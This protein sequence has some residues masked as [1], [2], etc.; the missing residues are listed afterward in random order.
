MLAAMIKHC[1]ICGKYIEWDFHGLCHMCRVAAEQKEE[2]EQDRRA[3]VAVARA[4]QLE[5]AAEAAWVTHITDDPC[6]GGACEMLPGGQ[7]LYCEHGRTLHMAYLD[8]VDATA[9]NYDALPAP[10][11]AEIESRE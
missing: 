7:W 6:V 10:L 5:R 4:L 9:A 11:R 2:R 3:L 8:A 1:V